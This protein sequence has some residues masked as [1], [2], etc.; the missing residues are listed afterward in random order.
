[1]SHLN[2]LTIF[3][4]FDTSIICEGV[5]LL[6]RPALV[7]DLR[8]LILLCH[9]AKIRVMKYLDSLNAV[10]AEVFKCNSA[11]S[12]R[13]ARRAKRICPHNLSDFAQRAPSVGLTMRSRASFVGKLRTFKVKMGDDLG[14]KF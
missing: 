3:F 1:M 6:R 10:N 14:G 12:W 11:A 5:N 9:V 2:L 13:E 8:Y 7:I 4:A